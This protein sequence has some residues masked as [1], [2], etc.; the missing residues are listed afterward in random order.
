MTRHGHLVNGREV[1]A[2]RHFLDRYERAMGGEELDGILA[3]SDGGT[4]TVKALRTLLAEHDA[5]RGEAWAAQ[6]VQ[7][8]HTPGNRPPAW[9]YDLLIAV[10]RYEDEHGPYADG[11]TCF[12][13]LVDSMVP[14][15]EIEKAKAIDAYWSEKEPT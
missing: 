15:E 4:L 5:Y 3:V 1:A 6:S 13:P 9:A 8:E 7:A 14:P 2:V 11:W 12:G 10:L